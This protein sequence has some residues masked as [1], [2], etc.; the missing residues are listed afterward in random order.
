MSDKSKLQQA[1]YEGSIQWVYNEEGSGAKTYGCSVYFP[2]SLTNPKTQSGVTIDPGFDLGQPDLGTLNRILN[3]Y[4]LHDVLNKKLVDRLKSAVGNKGIYAALWFKENGRH[5]KHNFSVP[6]HIALNVL[7]DITAPE[8]WKPLVKAMPKL[9]R[10]K[11]P[12]IKKAVHTA[13]LSMS[14]NR[15]WEKTILLTKEFIEVGNYD[16]LA[17]KISNVRHSLKSLTDRRKREASLIYA[18]LE[19]QDD[20]EFTFEDVKPLPVTTIPSAYK[21][22]VIK[23]IEFEYKHMELINGTKS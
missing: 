9:L 1:G 3:I 13:L 11:S 15:G 20:F 18:A 22:S 23:Q 12:Q 21:E 8:Y 4:I 19:Q 2:D 5:F 14:Y 16:G 10:I 6:Q 7:E 17:K